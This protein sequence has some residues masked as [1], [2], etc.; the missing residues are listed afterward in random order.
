MLVAPAV[1]PYGDHRVRTSIGGIPGV[2]MLFVMTI[3]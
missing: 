1:P 2:F 3:R